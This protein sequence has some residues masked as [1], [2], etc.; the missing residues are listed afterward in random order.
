[1][2][3]RPVFSIVTITYNAQ[4]TVERTI[5]SVIEQS[6]TNIEYI[7]IDGASTDDTMQI[8]GRY[9][10]SISKI[11]S[12]KDKGIYDAMNKGLALATG[13]YI[14]FMNSGDTI[15]SPDT[16]KRIVEQLNTLPDII[17]GETAI[18][19]QQNEFLYMRR[20][21]APEKLTWK[22]FKTGMLVSH[23]AFIAKRSIAPT[24]DLQYRFSADVDWCIRCMKIADTIHNTHLTLANYLN[25]GATTQN[26]KASLKERYNIMSKYYGKLPTMLRHI[27]FAI[28]YG[29][30]KIT[31]KT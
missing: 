27:G 9:K 7:I 11:V 31:G 22:S 19:N 16:V 2:Q 20:L 26:M 21:K 1:M 30:A 12:E 18:V 28:R 24:Y 5:R 4:N 3:Q 14:W 6:Y 25:E 23:Q 29:F 10:E 15:Y 13:D 8:V 17:Y